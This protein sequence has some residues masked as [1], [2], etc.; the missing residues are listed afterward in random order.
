M[1]AIS[2]FLK[3]EFRAVLQHGGGELGFSPNLPRMAG[4]DL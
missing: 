4:K 1:L 2:P 3:Q